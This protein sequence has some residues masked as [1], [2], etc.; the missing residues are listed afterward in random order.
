MENNIYFEVEIKQNALYIRLLMDDFYINYSDITDII[1]NTN[2]FIK[3][4]NKIITTKIEPLTFNNVKFVCCD[5]ANLIQLKNINIKKLEDHLKYYLPYIYK[6][7]PEFSNKIVFILNIKGVDN[8][9]NFE[10]IKRHF[11]KTKK[12]IRSYL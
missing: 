9:N 10:N 6:I 11:I 8:F 2:I 12:Q 1:D 7:E 4:I 5:S 3:G